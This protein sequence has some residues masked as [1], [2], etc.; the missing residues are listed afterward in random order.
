MMVIHGRRA[1]RVGSPPRGARWRVRQQPI[2]NAPAPNSQPMNKAS[3]G[4]RSSISRDAA[5]LRKQRGR[6]VFLSP[7]APAKA[8][9]SFA[10]A[11]GDNAR[12][13]GNPTRCRSTR[14]EICRRALGCTISRRRGYR[15]PDCPRVS[16]KALA[17]G[18]FFG[19]Q[20]GDATAV[21]LSHSG[22]PNGLLRGTARRI[23][24]SSASVCGARR[25]PSNGAGGS[26]RPASSDRVLSVARF[27]PQRPRRRQASAWAT[28]P[29]RTRCVAKKTEAANDAR[30]FTI[31][32]FSI[33]M[34]AAGLGSGAS[35]NDIR[36][37]IPL[38][39]ASAGL[40]CRGGEIAVDGRVVHGTPAVIGQRP[41]EAGGAVHGAAAA[42]A[43][44][45]QVDER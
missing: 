33:G 28:G 13:A 16:G 44:V 11:K 17:A 18:R 4:N 30:L 8:A 41:M 25:G 7:F 34:L 38:M 22:V 27:V 37:G 10:G 15:S 12:I 23:A 39:S 45:V 19:G 32:R 42:D 21:A 24:A 36:R 26:G 31:V 14:R 3:I 20:K 43:V 35:G 29:A 9:R 5:P 6:V 1:T 2:E 40:R